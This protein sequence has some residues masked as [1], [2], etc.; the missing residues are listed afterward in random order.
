M[1]TQ[2]SVTLP[3]FLGTRASQGAVPTRSS[4]SHGALWQPGPALCQPQ[5]RSSRCQTRPI[6]PGS[7]QSH[8]TARVTSQRS[9]P[10]QRH[11]VGENPCTTRDRPLWIKLA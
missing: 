6:Q 4:P 10:S 1:E 2:P 9:H 3:A 5:P 8:G 11:H 7:K